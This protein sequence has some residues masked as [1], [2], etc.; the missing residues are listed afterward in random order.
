LF[1]RRPQDIGEEAPQDAK[2]E[3]ISMLDVCG[4][5]VCRF[6]RQTQ[7]WSME[8]DMDKI[9]EAVLALLYLTL[10]DQVRAWKSALRR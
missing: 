3:P 2:R 4:S 5:R 10:H 1:Q 6:V 8:I 7:G 9:D